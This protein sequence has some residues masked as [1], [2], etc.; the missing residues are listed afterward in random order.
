MT[1]PSP[2]PHATFNGEGGV[3]VVRRRRLLQRPRVEWSIAAQSTA[4]QP[5]PATASLGVSNFYRVVWDFEKDRWMAFF[6]CKGGMSCAAIS[7]HLCGDGD[8]VQ[9][10]TRASSTSRASVARPPQPLPGLDGC[11]PLG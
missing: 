3:L 2:C 10:L 8:L 1:P 9:V 11:P 5:Q 6:G 7:T 4:P